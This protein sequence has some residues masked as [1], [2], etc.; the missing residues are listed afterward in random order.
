MTGYLKGISMSLLTALKLVESKRPIHLSEIEVRRLKL[1][2]NID[3]QIGY[4]KSISEGIHPT[5]VRSFTMKNKISGDVFP[6][7][8]K[9]NVRIWWY[10]SLDGKTVI[11]LRYGNKRIELGNGKTGVELDDKSKVGETLDLLKRAV[12]A[13]ELDEGIQAAVGNFGRKIRG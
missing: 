8:R 4:A 10:T 11:E 2:R 12:I 6:I 7:E 1:V 9:S 13:G 3:L 5:V